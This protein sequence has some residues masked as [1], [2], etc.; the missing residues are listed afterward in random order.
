MNNSASNQINCLQGIKTLSIF[1]IILGH[2]FLFE[3]ISSTN[4]LNVIKWSLQLQSSFV[5]AAYYAVDTFLVISGVLSGYLFCNS[6]S[7]RSFL[8]KQVPKMYLH[9]FVRLGP[10]LYAILIL[11]ITL[12][13]RI[14]FGPYKLLLNSFETPKCLDKFTSEVF[15][16]QN[17]HHPRTDVG[18]VCIKPP[19]CIN[20]LFLVFGHYAFMVPSDRNA[21]LY[22]ATNFH[23]FATIENKFLSFWGYINGRHFDFYHFW[24]YLLQ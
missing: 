5:Q 22:I 11:Y 8:W 19:F 18:Y 4:I 21:T 17:Y 2:T 7:I 3:T 13:D 24:S 16:I 9:R 23:R 10:G 6:N 1:W 20:L 12:G 15:F 14:G